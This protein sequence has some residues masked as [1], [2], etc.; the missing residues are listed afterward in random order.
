M[1]N[2][3]L[4]MHTM[5]RRAART[6][7]SSTMTWVVGVLWLAICGT[8]SYQLMARDFIPGRLGRPRAAWPEATALTRPIG[9]TS[10]LAFVHPQCPCTRATVT[11]LIRTM[12][13]HPGMAATAV[14]FVPANPRQ[15]PTWEDGAYVKSLRAAL[16]LIHIVY[17]A[18]GVEAQRFGALT[19]GTILVY[20]PIGRE[21][22]RGGITDRRGGEGDNR[23]LR[24]LVE[25]LRGRQRSVAAS[26]VFGCPLVVPE[27]ISPERVGV[28]R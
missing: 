12:T 3:T 9:T 16:P 13:R 10:L 21:I 2:A 28:A 4:S 1:D 23:G 8:L 15:R 19:S 7:P 20:D 27:N 22:F 25:L 11:Q 6:I 17:D 24:Q 5:R 26:A 18:G 14:V